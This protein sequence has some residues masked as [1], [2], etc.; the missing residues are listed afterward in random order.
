M[1]ARVVL[2]ECGKKFGVWMDAS[3]FDLTPK[4]REVFNAIIDLLAPYKDAPRC[5]GFPK[6]EGDLP[7]EPHSEECPLYEHG[8]D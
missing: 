5:A 1:S 2:L 4:D 8:K 3:L 6:C 7:G